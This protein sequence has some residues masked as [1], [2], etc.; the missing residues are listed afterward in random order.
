MRPEKTTED[1]GFDPPTVWS[2]ARRTRSVAHFAEIPQ[3]AYVTGI[4]LAV[5]A[6]L[7]LFIALV[8]AFVVRR[9]SPAEDWRHLSVP[10]VLWLNT[11]ILLGTSFTLA[12]SR[13]RFLAAEETDFRHWWTVTA[14]LGV[15]FVAGQTMAW[16]QLSAAGIHFST[17]SSSSFFYLL[18]AVQG[19]YVLGGVAALLL[20]AFRPTR[21]L[22]RVT[23]IRVISIYW[24]SMVGIWIGLFLLLILD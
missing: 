22:E 2:A 3:Q 17:N 4:T 13:K 23:A 6:I 8:S 5:A 18:T 20:V 14:I 12:G 7:S 16:R 24:H 15:F 11:A 19:L 21:H 9:G 10:P 1:S